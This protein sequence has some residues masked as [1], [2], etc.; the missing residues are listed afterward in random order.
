MARILLSGEGVDTARQFQAIASNFDKKHLIFAQQQL[1]KGAIDGRSYAASPDGKTCGCL[2]GVLALSEVG[3]DKLQSDGFPLAQFRRACYLSAQ[4]NNF[5]GTRGSDV[6]SFVALIY[7]GDKPKNSR[8]ALK[9]DRWL[10]KAIT[11]KSV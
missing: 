4:Y 1:R 7:P 11:G 9:L 2:F 8:H 6:E 3:F 10:T 5:H